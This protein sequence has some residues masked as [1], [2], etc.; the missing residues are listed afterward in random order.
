L[1][2]S[3]NNAAN[4]FAFIEYDEDSGSSTNEQ[5]R[6]KIG[7]AN[8]T[9]GAS[10]EDVIS[11]YAG[12]VTDDIATIDSEGLKLASGK[13]IYI[14]GVAVNLSTNSGTEWVYNGTNINNVNAGN[15]GIGTASPVAKL[16]VN[17]GG[18]GEALRLRGTSYHSHFYHGTNE[19]TYIR[20]G[21]AAGN[22][23]IADA[24]NYVGIGTASNVSEKLQVYGNLR[25]DNGS[26]TN[27]QQGAAIILVPII[28]LDMEAVGMELQ[29]VIMEHL[30]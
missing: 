15:V 30:A 9:V 16:D 2:P 26:T 11:F 22:V 27:N 20:P 24:G 21:L 19:D 8:D 10:H 1:F 7:C 13:A 29:M 18:S 5:G 12:S 3:V 4:D 25:L 6:L 28:L 23:Y 17:A 14:G